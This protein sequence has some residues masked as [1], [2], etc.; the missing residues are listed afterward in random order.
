MKPKVLVTQ[1]IP[2]AVNDTFNNELDLIYPSKEKASYSYNEVLEMIAQYDALLTIFNKGDKAV[3]DA[4][5]RLKAIANLGV[6]YDSI[7]V[8]YATEKNIAVINSPTS[9][10]EATAELTIGL[11]MASM[12]NIVAYD[13]SIRNGEWSSTA[14]EDKA[15]EVFGHTLGIAGFGRIGK[16]VCKKAQVLGM[17]VAYYDP[18]RLSPEDE[19]EMNVEYMPLEKL[20]SQCNC[21]SLHMPYTPQNHHLVDEN[22]LSTMKKGSFLINV[23]RGPIVKESSLVEALNNGTLKGAALDVYEFE[24]K[25]GNDLLACENV[26]LNPHVGTQTMQVRINMCNESL[27]GVLAV[28]KGETP[29]NLVNKNIK[30]GKC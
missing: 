13:K 26:V 7:D 9:V 6:G 10:T 30:L 14:F 16:S 24:P 22:L 2:D 23:A 4:G 11:I 21:V 5:V 28:L 15:V 27:S 25:I 3:I 12:R 29:Y 20:F 18:F 1:W 19:K 17:K 8:E